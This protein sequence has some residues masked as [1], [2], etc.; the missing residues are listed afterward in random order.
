MSIEMRRISVVI[1]LL[2]AV[3]ATVAGQARAAD[4]GPAS[5]ERMQSLDRSILAGLNEIR[6]QHGLRPLI[7]SPALQDA[8]IFQSR[9]MLE[10]GFFAHDSR[11][12]SSFVTRLKR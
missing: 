4:A 12:G 10:A 9:S 2:L 5:I 1:A 6:V 8:A 3:A 11:D 7:L